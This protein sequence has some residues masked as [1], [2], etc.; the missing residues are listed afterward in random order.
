MLHAPV[1]RLRH[2][3]QVREKE[4]KKGERR[5]KR[6]LRDISVWCFPAGLTFC[7]IIKRKEKGKRTVSEISSLFVLSSPIKISLYSKCTLVLNLLVEL[8]PLSIWHLLHISASASY[9]LIASLK[10]YKGILEIW[11]QLIFSNPEVR[12]SAIWG[13]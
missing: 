3:S 12:S 4:R 10:H 8:F 13:G 2:F 9:R 11:L 1:R 6:L 5:K 7:Y